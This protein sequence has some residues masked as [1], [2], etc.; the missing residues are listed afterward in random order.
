METL[1]TQ[2]DRACQTLSTEE[3]CKLGDEAWEA[4][5]YGRAVRWYQ[6]AAQKDCAEAQYQCGKAYSSGRGAELDRDQALEWYEKAAMHHHEKA[7]RA[8]ISFYDRDVPTFEN[9]PRA[10]YW[11]E[12]L[13]QDGDAQAQYQC[14]RRY[15]NAIGTPQDLDKAARWARSAKD[16][17]VEGADELWADILS[18]WMKF[19][20]PYYS[21]VAA[22]KDG[23]YAL[24]LSSFQKAVNQG[25]KEA[26]YALGRMYFEGKGT[27]VDY[28]KAV[29]LFEKA[30][31]GGHA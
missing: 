15:Y 19:K 10:L 20:E 28:S 3:I 18:D 29:S 24:A 2:I 27:Q 4:E 26:M 5:D 11:Y 6:H 16:H 17:K 23:N 7:I 14:A 1:F 13:A 8:C 9:K 21:G 30:A 25:D 22:D 31:Q 12:Q